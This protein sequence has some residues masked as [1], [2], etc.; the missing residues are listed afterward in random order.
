V[1]FVDIVFA[2]L[3]ANNLL[4]F[5]YLGLG[6][7]L[8]DGGAAHL[9]RRTL[10]LAV[11]LVVSSALFWLPDHFLFQPFHLTFL[12][13]LLVLAILGLV[14]LAYSAAAGA[15]SGPWPRARELLVHSLLVG[16]LFL[17]GPSSPDLLAVLTA[18][19]AVSLGYGGALVLLVAVFRRLSRENLPAFI[20]G[21]PLQLLTLGLVWLILQGLGFAFAGK[22]V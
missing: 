11:L 13:T 2:S 15:L 14:T 17:V 19:L 8:G 21:L 1:N 5:H 20:Q 9:G 22:G 6:E 16:G 7:F 3:F 10:T 12:R 18:A 4:F